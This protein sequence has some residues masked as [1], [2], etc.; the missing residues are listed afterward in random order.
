MLSPGQGLETIVTVDIVLK[1]ES[2]VQEKHVFRIKNI[3]HIHGAI[4][5]LICNQ[6]ILLMTKKELNDSILS[7]KFQTDFAYHIHFMIKSFTLKINEKNIRITGN[8][9]TNE[10]LILIN[11][12]P[13]SS[14]FDIIDFTDNF[15]CSNCLH[16][17]IE[18]LKIMIVE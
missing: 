17:A 2:I 4:N 9:L 6:S 3:P 5:G 14:I 10:A 11:S 12:L 1:D 18:P 7:V 15:E 16:N 13:V 8:K